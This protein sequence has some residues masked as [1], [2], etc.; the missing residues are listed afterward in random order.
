MSFLN[1]LS[2]KDRNRLRTII[3]KVHF[4]HYPKNMITNYEADKLI[5]AFSEEVIYNM[6]KADVGVNVD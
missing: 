5:E 6:L 1:T 2:L 4:Q 3:K